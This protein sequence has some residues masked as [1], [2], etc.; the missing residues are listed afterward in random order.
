MHE[1]SRDSRIPSGTS[2]RRLNGARDAARGQSAV[3][4]CVEPAVRP[5]F[6]PACV[7]RRGHRGRRRSV[8][9]V[10]DRDHAEGYSRHPGPPLLRL[11]SPGLQQ[12]AAQGAAE[13]GRH[14]AARL[15]RYRDRSLRGFALRGLRAAAG[16][17]RS[18][19]QRLQIRRL[20][21]ALGPVLLRLQDP[22]PGAPERELVLHSLSGDRSRVRRALEKTIHTQSQRR[23]RVVLH[24]RQATDRK[25]VLLERRLVRP[26][27][28]RLSVNFFRRPYIHELQK[29]HTGA[30]VLAER[31]GHPAGHHRN[32]ALVDTACGHALVSCVNHDSHPTRLEHIVDAV[33]DLR[34]QLFLDLKTTRVAFDDTRELADPNF[35]VG[36]Q[37][38]DVRAADDRGHV[39]LSMGLEG[40]VPQHD[41]LVVTTDFLE[42]AP[43]V[44]GRIQLVAGNPDTKDKDNTQKRLKKTLAI[45]VVPRPSQKRTYS[46]FRGL[47]RDLSTTLT[48]HAV[49]WCS[50]DGA[51]RAKTNSTSWEPATEALAYPPLLA[52]DRAAARAWHGRSRRTPAG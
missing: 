21:S 4:P 30:G 8:G 16:S 35:L 5:V 18:Q 52:V 41:H 10:P 49:P 44:L 48:G 39:M 19:R 14:R 9:T 23:H 36:R 28:D 6:F 43:Q 15:P 20:Q 12:S 37:V 46:V 1:A 11:E 50:Y 25:R 33:R 24:G 13:M 26:R 42:G 3:Y 17:R 45:R 38:A 34:G 47:P 2:I 7:V 29:L 27:P 40:D 51:G 32:T 31:P 22:L